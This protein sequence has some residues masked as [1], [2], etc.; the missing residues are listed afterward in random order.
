MRNTAPEKVTRQDRNVLGKKLKIWRTEKGW[1]LKKVA[2][3]FG[4]EE[5]TWSRWERG[6]RFPSPDFIP[7]LA[8]FT[9]I[10]LCC[11]FLELN[12][13]KEACARTQRSKLKKAG[14]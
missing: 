6:Q 7:L 1:P 13:P 3:E 12:V 9:S 4:T 8:T 5:S 10:P 11:F 14:E 2:K